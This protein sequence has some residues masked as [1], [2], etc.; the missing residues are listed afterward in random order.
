MAINIKKLNLPD[1]DY[2]DVWHDYKLFQSSGE[3]WRY[4]MAEDEDF[5][6]G[7][8][9]TDTQKEYLE[10]LKSFLIFLNMIR[11]DELTKVGLDDHVLETLRKI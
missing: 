3:E 8:Q 6:L 10:I 1:V 7:N 4:Q 5:Y 2:T 11:E 9:L